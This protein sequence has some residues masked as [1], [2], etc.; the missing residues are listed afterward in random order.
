MGRQVRP[1]TPFRLATPALDLKIH[2]AG[3]K[4]ELF[5]KSDQQMYDINALTPALKRSFEL[6]LR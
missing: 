5:K 4:I 1:R 6:F 2:Q 3:I